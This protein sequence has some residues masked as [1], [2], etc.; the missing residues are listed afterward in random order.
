[1][2]GVEKFMLTNDVISY[3]VPFSLSI[4]IGIFEAWLMM[5]ITVVMSF[6]ENRIQKKKKDE[7]KKEG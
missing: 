3:F 2:S 7:K 6:Q 1:M 5:M 4:F